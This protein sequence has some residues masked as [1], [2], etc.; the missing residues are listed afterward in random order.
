MANQGPVG[1]YISLGTEGVAG[2]AVPNQL[3]VPGVEYERARTLIAQ[4]IDAAIEGAASAGAERFLVND[5]YGQMHNTLRVMR[6]IRAR[7]CLSDMRNL[8]P[9]GRRSSVA[10]SCVGRD[11][12]AQRRS[13]AW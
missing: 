13:T 11:R 4:G 10:S 5:S 6:S 9:W 7:S 2:V 1:V 8:G 12:P 3:S